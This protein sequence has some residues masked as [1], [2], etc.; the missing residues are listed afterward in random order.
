VK[1]VSNLWA[2]PLDGS[3]PKALTDFQSGQIFGFA[4]S[5]TG[6]LALAR[7]THTSDAILIS[8]FK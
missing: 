1:G 5:R 2:Q 3:S 4:W 8:N 6:D 7:G